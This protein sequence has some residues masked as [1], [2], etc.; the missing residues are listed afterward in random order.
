MKRKK[1]L[2][3]LVLF[4][5]FF[6]FLA[7]FFSRGGNEPGKALK[8]FS[9][10]ADVVVRDFRLDQVDESTVQWTVFA[11]TARY[12]MKEKKVT[13]E[14]VRVE[15]KDTGGVY[16]ITARR[17]EVD[18]E[19]RNMDLY[20]DVVLTSDR[21]DRCEADE[22]HYRHEE[23][24]IFTPGEFRI[25]YGDMEIRGEGLILRPGEKRFEAAGA[26]RARIAGFSL[27]F[28]GR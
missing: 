2:V 9:E 7:F 8:V 24:K 12:S 13:L 19:K 11:D 20:G 15:M 5:A 6:F 18:T 23:G 3:S 28:P 16:D 26:V 4:I 10:K 14:N 22:L 17:G 1:V 25:A 21:G 27:S